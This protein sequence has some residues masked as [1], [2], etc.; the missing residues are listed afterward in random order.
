MAATGLAGNT[1]VSKDAVG[2][3]KSLPGASLLRGE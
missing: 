3:P 1:N 2:A